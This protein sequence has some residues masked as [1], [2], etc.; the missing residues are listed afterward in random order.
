[1]AQN[2]FLPKS[3][4]NVYHGK[5][6]PKILATSASFKKLHKVNF[7]PPPKKTPKNSSNL[8]TLCVRNAC[9]SS[10]AIFS[11]EQNT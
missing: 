10:A 1:V 4:R 6:N 7:Y 11:D 2:I 9:S 5:S 3:M 8:V